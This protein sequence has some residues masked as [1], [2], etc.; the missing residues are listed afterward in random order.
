MFSAVKRVPH[1]PYEPSRESSHREDVG[2]GKTAQWLRTLAA[3]IEDMSN[4]LSGCS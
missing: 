3:F 4:P 2:A 1:I